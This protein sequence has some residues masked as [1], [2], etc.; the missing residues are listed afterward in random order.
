[1]VPANVPV[2]LSG[3]DANE[4]APVKPVDCG[5]DHI[6]RDAAG[7]ELSV[8]Y[9][10]PPI[11]GPGVVHVL[12][13][14]PVYDAPLIDTHR[15]PGVRSQ[16][17]ARQPNPRF[18]AGGREAFRSRRE[19]GIRVER[20]VTSTLKA[21]ARRLSGADMVSLRHAAAVAAFSVA[22]QTALSGKR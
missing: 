3:H 7:D 14:E 21:T 4:A 6:L 13:Q 18:I 8:R 1:M 20:P 15:A 9:P 10:Q 22:D 16:Q 2:T 17:F 12:D 5:C 11:H 19:A